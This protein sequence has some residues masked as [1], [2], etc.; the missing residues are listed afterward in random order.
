MM[1][2]QTNV[3]RRPGDKERQFRHD[4]CIFKTRS[5]NDLNTSVRGFSLKIQ[6]KYA[7]E[8]RAKN[9][10]GRAEADN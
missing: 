2:A 8:E 3:E 1:I 10:F 7:A 6:G 4:V 5:N 9:S